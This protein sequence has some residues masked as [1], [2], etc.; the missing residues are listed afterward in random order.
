MLSL[1]YSIRTPLIRCQFI[2]FQSCLIYHEFGCCIEIVYQY[3]YCN[4]NDQEFLQTIYFLFSLYSSF[5]YRQYGT[6]CASCKVGVCPEDL[7][8]RAVN[9]VYHVSC[10]KCSVCKRQLNT[11]EQLYL[12]QVSHLLVSIQDNETSLYCM[13]VSI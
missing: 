8:R 4:Y 2:S 11:G 10:F 7:V 6:Q 13:S 12:V 3:Y 9:N 5:H 1:V